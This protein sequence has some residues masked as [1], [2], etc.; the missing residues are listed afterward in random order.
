MIP[1]SQLGDVI[2]PIYKKRREF[3]GAFC[4]SI[5]KVSMDYLWSIYGF[6]ME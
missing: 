3:H 6:G 2:S 4:I 5:H 1:D